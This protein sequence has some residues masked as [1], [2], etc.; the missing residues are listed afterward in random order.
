MNARHAVLVVL[1][2]AVTLTS[3]ASA[4]PAPAKQ[5]VAINMKIYPQG[6]FVLTPLQRGTLKR[7]AG[8]INGTWTSIPGRKV[9]RDG[10]EGGHD[11]RRRRDDT[12]RE[13]RNA[14]D[15]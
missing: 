5:R 10:Q 8:T 13:A 9:M 11:L 4:G 2:A 15:S 1:V 12:H 7:D 14:H 3:V 6:T